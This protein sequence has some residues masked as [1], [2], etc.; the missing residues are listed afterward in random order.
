MPQDVSRRSPPERLPTWLVTPTS[1]AA[2]LFGL[3]L[4]RVSLRTSNFNEAMRWLV[5]NLGQE[6]IEP[7]DLE[8]MG[9][10]LDVRLRAYAGRGS[11]ADERLLAERCAFKHEVSRFSQ[12]GAGRRLCLPDA[13]RREAGRVPPATAQQPQVFDPV[14]IDRLILEAVAQRLPQLPTPQAG[15]LVPVRDLTRSLKAES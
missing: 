7:P 4:L 2:Q 15:S 12:A 14:M 11:P 8:A 13:V 1:Q 3:P 10:L 6:L 5:D 9:T